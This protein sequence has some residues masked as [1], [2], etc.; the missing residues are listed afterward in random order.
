[1]ES[2]KIYIIDNNKLENPI[3]EI[4]KK[5][6]HFLLAYYCSVKIKSRLKSDL[7]NKIYLLDID[8]TLAD[9]FHSY[10]YYFKSYED[11]LSSLA[12]FI[13]MR[14]KY[15]EIFDNN[16]NVFFIS[17]RK[18]SSQATTFKWL[19]SNGLRIERE[20]IFN[21]NNVNVKVSL[22]KLL[23]K[24]NHYHI[25]LID[26]LSYNHENGKVKYYENQI[27]AINQF[28]VLH[29]DAKQIQEIND[30]L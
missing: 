4:V 6:F 10:K 15:I 14:N 18:I 24:N 30:K 22:I 27:I 9:T 25:T 11:R 28:K 7:G 3:R 13:G 29:I 1:M 26:D 12:I 5:V 20:N 21:V 17:A 16:E 2:K 23:N 8:N 19:K